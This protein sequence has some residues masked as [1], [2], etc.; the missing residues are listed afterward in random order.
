MRLGGEERWKK[1]AKDEIE[2]VEDREF[3]KAL[4]EG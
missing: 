4:N 1:K 3:G 2:K